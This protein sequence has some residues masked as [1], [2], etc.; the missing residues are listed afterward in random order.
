MKR[1]SPAKSFTNRKQAERP[2]NLTEQNEVLTLKRL[3]F[4]ALRAAQRKFFGE[5]FLIFDE[6][7]EFRRYG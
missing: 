4:S 1:P 2:Q 3:E 5:A 6:V 7:S